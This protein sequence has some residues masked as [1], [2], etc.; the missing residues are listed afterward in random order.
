[1]HSFRRFISIAILCVGVAMPIF[2]LTQPAAETKAFYEGLTYRVD[3]IEMTAI[4]DVNPKLEGSIDIPATIDINEDTYTVIGVGD[5][6][7]KGSKG[8][9]EISLPQTIQ[10]VYRSAFEGTAFY[11]DTLNWEHGELYIDSIL[12]SV[13]PDSTK[14]KYHVRPG[15]TVIAVGAL[16]DCKEVT[17]VFIPNTV[18]DIAAET[19]KGCKS[20]KKFHLGRGVKHIGKNAFVGTAIWENEK[21]W[22]KGLLYIDTCLI[23]ANNNIKPNQVIRPDSRLI[24]DGAFAD[25]KR[26]KTIELSPLFQ[27]IGDET[28]VR[29]AGLE[30]ITLPD[31]IKR[32]GRMAFADCQNIKLIE[33]GDSVT[34]IGDRAFSGCTM[35]RKLHFPPYVRRIA[36]GCCYQCVTLDDLQWP[37]S[38]K[39]IGIAAFRECSQLIELKELPSGLKKI[40]NG[41][42]YACTSLVE[43]RLPESVDGIAEHTFENCT[44][45]RKVVLTDAVTLLGDCCF[46]NC[47][48]LEVINMPQFLFRIGEYAFQNCTMFKGALL[49]DR[50][51]DIAKGAFQNCPSIEYF[52]LPLGT[53]YIEP[54]TFAGCKLLTEV[55][56]H[57]GLKE[58]GESA[59]E[60]CNYLKRV[61]LPEGV[62]VHKNAFKNTKTDVV[63]ISKDDVPAD[64][65]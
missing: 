6:A 13:N 33:M 36:E 44:A 3:N 34:F 49:P 64:R 23:A 53:K 63:F 4:V 52:T 45:L 30:K 10:F 27:T 29:C 48:E 47:K 17:N 60:G 40:G 18:T 14:S 20:I 24:A 15:T 41:A 58:I 28:F 22:K 50:V 21:A 16:L 59:F 19:F 7:F 31:S 42:F 1:M 61:F 25:N 65:K 38:L 5:K 12:I 32:I 26:L 54:Y 11:K 8:L 57:T 46:R 37:D 55:E 51:E 56:F 2:S 62:E 43:V 9:T 35:L 39:E